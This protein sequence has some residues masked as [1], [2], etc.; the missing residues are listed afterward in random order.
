MRGDHLGVGPVYIHIYISIGVTSCKANWEKKGLQEGE[1]K[2][3]APHYITGSSG[4][5]AYAC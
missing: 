5:T 4:Y 2:E 3:T 1:I